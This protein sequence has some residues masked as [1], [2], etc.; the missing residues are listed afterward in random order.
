MNIWWI[1]YCNAL[2]IC[3]ILYVTVEYTPSV[4]VC[5]LCSF[6][7]DREYGFITCANMERQLVR[8]LCLARFTM[9]NIIRGTANTGNSQLSGIDTWDYGKCI[10]GSAVLRSVWKW[11]SCL[12]YKLRYVWIVY[13]QFVNCLRD[14]GGVS[15][16]GIWQ[17]DNF[18]KRS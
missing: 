11:S 18:C 2:L 3:W 16:L 5:F 10:Y 6:E 9:Y 12:V 15:Y 1:L 13:M 4:C 14:D 8:L 17:M 7:L